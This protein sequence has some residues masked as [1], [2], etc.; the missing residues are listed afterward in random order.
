MTLAFIRSLIWWQRAIL[1]AKPE[2][3]VWSVDLEEA[4]MTREA[5]EEWAAFLETLLTG[6]EKMLA[7]YESRHPGIER[8]GVMKERSVIDSL[9]NARDHALEHVASFADASVKADR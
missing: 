5:A 7:S 4:A 8:P 9:R 3:L 2:A 1:S 6:S